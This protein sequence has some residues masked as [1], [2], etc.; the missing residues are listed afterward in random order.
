M[1]QKGNAPQAS[2]SWVHFNKRLFLFL[3]ASLLPARHPVSVP[4]APLAKPGRSRRDWHSWRS[5]SSLQPLAFPSSGARHGAR[6]VFLFLNIKPMSCR[7][8]RALLRIRDNKGKVI[9]LTSARLGP[10]GCR[11]G[12]YRN[13]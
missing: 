10:G 9:K 6:A 3:I 1:N 4:R 13:V 11:G 5:L 8:V 2:S 7:T 12:I